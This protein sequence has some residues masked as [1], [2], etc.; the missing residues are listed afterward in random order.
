M[1]LSRGRLGPGPGQR[2]HWHPGPSSA[3]PGPPGALHSRRI[4]VSVGGRYKGGAG[5]L[6]LYGSAYGLI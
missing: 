2:Q 1:M 6:F 3:A 5:L 4:A